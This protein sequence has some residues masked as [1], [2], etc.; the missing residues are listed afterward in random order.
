MFLEAL[1]ALEP[2]VVLTGPAE[3]LVELGF[4]SSAIST[5]RNFGNDSFFVASTYDHG[6]ELW[7]LDSG[8]PTGIRLV[9]DINPGRTSS[10]PTNL[11][12]LGG[13]LY[14]T[15]SNLTDGTE[16]W[17]INGSGLAEMVEDAVTGGGIRPSSSGSYPDKLTNVGGTLF[18]RANDGTN[19]YELWRVNSSGLAEMVED[20]IP[21]GGIAALNSSSNP[22]NLVYVGGTLYFSATDEGNGNELWR[23]N[24]LGVAEIVEDVMPGGGINPGTA[25]SNPSNLTNVGGTLFFSANDGTTGNELWLVRPTSVAN[26]QVFYNRSTSTVFGDGS[27]NPVS[28]IDSTK[29]A[30]LPGQT[31]SSANY[32]NYSRG[33]NGLVVDLQA[34]ANLAEISA[35][36]FQFATWNTF[37]DST[38]NFVPI[39]PAV[40]VSTYPGGGVNGADRV[41]L[42]FANNAIQNAWLKVTVLADVN[43]GL[44]TNDVFYFGN[45]RFDITPSTPFPSQQITI[46][47]FDTNAVRA[48]QGQNSGVISNAFDVDRNGVVNVFDTN[49]VRAGQGVTSL[50]SFTAPASAQLRLSNQFVDSLYV[51]LGW[52]DAFGVNKKTRSQTRG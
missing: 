27:G 10:N 30:L 20:T 28:S 45:A 49:A 33:L 11:T 35:S 1:E 13:T 25:N 7:K 37:P 3:M 15:A 48:N 17:R 38:P 2:R 9:A 16:L 34:P 5:I 39:T 44:A 52:L 19:G 24:K 8:S 40:T 18:F 29:I 14:F 46:N 51:D 4:D 41:K 47:I 32:T 31:T 36:S 22:S 50:R 43:T 26:R 42:E 12:D 23:I 6:R 21:G